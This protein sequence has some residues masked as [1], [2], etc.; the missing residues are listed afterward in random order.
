[1]E[2]LVY[3]V[4]TAG[5]LLGISRTTVYDFVAKGV[6]PAIRL[7]KKRLVIPKAAIER[8]LA[9]AGTQKKT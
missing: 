3:D 5:K 2:S 9:E 6:L 7:G 1:M 4:Q 8:M